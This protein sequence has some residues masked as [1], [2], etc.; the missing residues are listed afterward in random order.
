M[1][2]TDPTGAMSGAMVKVSRNGGTEQER[3][4]VRLDELQNPHRDPTER[5]G[6]YGPVIGPAIGGYIRPALWPFPR[7]GRHSRPT[8][9][10]VLVE[11]HDN[12]PTVWEALDA[13]AAGFKPNRRYLRQRAARM[14]RQAEESR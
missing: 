3:C 11:P 14:R 8:N 9:V 5:G 7:S 2:T 13:R 12:D 1:A 6:D 10:K 4:D